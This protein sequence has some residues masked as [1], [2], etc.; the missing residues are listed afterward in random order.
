MGLERPWENLY[1]RTDV[2]G[3]QQYAGTLKTLREKETVV[4]IG[5]SFYIADFVVEK[6][7]NRNEYGLQQSAIL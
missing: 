2:V 4:H 3:S 5:W 7:A 1:P 6:D